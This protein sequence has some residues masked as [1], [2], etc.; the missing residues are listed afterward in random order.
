MSRYNFKF[1]FKF[2]KSIRNLMY[3]II[4]RTD[5]IANIFLFWRKER[6]G[7]LRYKRSSVSKYTCIEVTA[8]ARPEFQLKNS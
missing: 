3:M 8:E 1:K 6:F 4:L 7:K 2:F 5:F